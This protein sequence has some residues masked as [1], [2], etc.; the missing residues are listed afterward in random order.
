MLDT[1]G[2][3]SEESNDSLEFY[4]TPI[5]E[6]MNILTRVKLLGDTILDPCAGTGNFKKAMAQ[7]S[8]LKNKTIYESDIHG[9]GYC[10]E[11]D[12]L[13]AE[14]YAD[15]SVDVVIMNPPFKTVEAFTN[16]ALKVAKKQVIL[17]ARFQFLET[18]GRYEKIFKTNPPHHAYLYVDRVGCYR[19]DQEGER[20][21]AMCYGWFVWDLEEPYVNTNLYWMRNA[22][23][24]NIK[25]TDEL[26]VNY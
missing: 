14:S 16:R 23:K 18:S 24:L 25:E 21:S 2:F 9:R 26:T 13:N 20:S 6:V 5:P 1:A 12:F 10:K 17:F 4:L 15:K 11:L 8:A 7:I 3:K 19:T 22:K